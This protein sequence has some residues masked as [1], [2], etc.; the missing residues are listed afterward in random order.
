MT[1]LSSQTMK[2]VTH[3]MRAT[4]KTIIS[5]KEVTQMVQISMITPTKVEDM[6]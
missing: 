5:A 6:N 3:K 2:S 1:C 4:K